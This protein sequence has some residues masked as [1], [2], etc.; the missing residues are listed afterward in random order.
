MEKLN[1][2]NITVNSSLPY[3][4]NSCLLEEIKNSDGSN[5]IE[6]ELFNIKLNR[7][8][9]YKAF[10]NINE[11][12]V[13]KDNCLDGNNNQFGIDLIFR[14]SLSHKADVYKTVIKLEAEQK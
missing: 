4:L 3:Q 9:D 7:E 8:T 13:L 10:N 6:K 1:A 2:I 5:K 11:K 14:G 12:L